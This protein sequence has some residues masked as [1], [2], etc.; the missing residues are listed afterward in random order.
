MVLFKKGKS[1]KL[2][3]IKSNIN[4]SKNDISSSSHN[5]EYKSNNSIDATNI[6]KLE[7]KKI[8]I[9]KFNKVDLSPSNKNQSQ[10]NSKRNQSYFNKKKLDFEGFALDKNFNDE[11]SCAFE[12]LINLTKINESNYA[13]NI[14]EN[15]TNNLCKIQLEKIKHKKRLEKS[16]ENM[17][18]FLNE[19]KSYCNDDRMF[20]NNTTIEK[21]KTVDQLIEKNFGKIKKNMFLTENRNRKI[22]RKDYNKY[23]DKIQLNE[24]KK[25]KDFLEYDGDLETASLRNENYT[26]SK[27]KNNSNKK[28]SVLNYKTNLNLENEVK[29]N[30]KNIA[31]KSERTKNESYIDN[32]IIEPKYLKLSKVNN[33]YYNTFCYGFFISGIPTPM[34]ENLIIEESINYLSP[35]CHKNCSSLFSIK[36]AIL[37]YFKNDL[38]EIE[39]S[40]LRKISNISFPLGIK[41]CIESSFDAKKTIQSPQQIFYNI[42]EN[43]NGERIY[44]CTKYF[45]IKENSDEFKKKY[46][47]DISL[48]LSE[49]IKNNKIFKKNELVLSQLLNS[50]TY[51]V[52]QSI[53]LLSKEPF[54]NPMATC[55]NGFIASI[56]EERANLINHIINEVPIPQKNNQIKFYL[57]PYFSP[58]ILNHEMNIY[59]VMAI[60]NQTK[61]K[62]SYYNLFLSREQLNYKKLYEYI[63]IEHIIFIFQMIILEQK[64]ILVDNNYK[65]LSELIFIF[66]N[67]IYPFSWRNNHIFP[68]ITFENI[69]FLQNK[70]PFICGMD[71]FVFSY[72][73]K[74]INNNTFNLENDI[75]IYNISQKCFIFSKNRKKITR[76]DLMHEY[77]L[78]SLPERVVN[79]ITKNIKFII[80]YINKND[81]M[82]NLKNNNNN[83][84]YEF[85]K[86]LILFKQNIEYDTKLAFIKGL[87]MLIGDYN[88]YTFFI[89]GEKPLFNKEAFIE[90]HKE[91]EF[92]YFLNQLIKTK[93][94]EEFLENEKNIYF[95]KKN[96]K[97]EN[98]KNEIKNDISIN[99]KKYYDTSYFIKIAYDFPDLINNYQI[100]KNSDSISNIMNKDTYFKAKTIC[101]KFKIIYESNKNNPNNLKEK[102][103]NNDNDSKNIQFENSQINRKK[104]NVLFS[105]KN[106]LEDIP[107]EKNIDTENKEF[108]NHKKSKNSEV[109]S[110]DYKSINKSGLKESKISTEV[111]TL[112]SQFNFINKN[113]IK[114]EKEENDEQKIIYININSNKNLFSNDKKNEKKYIIKKYLLTPFFLNLCRDDDVYIKEKITEDIII[115]EMK[116]YRKRKNIKDKIPPFSFLITIISKYINFD[117]Y[118]IKKSKIY[119]INDN[120]II[121][122]DK[123]EYDN[124]INNYLKESAKEV[125]S[126]KKKYFKEEISEK[127]IID[128]NNIY[129]K[130]EENILIN[131]FF[132][133]CIIN[134]PKIDNQNLILLKKLFSNIE[135][136]EYFANLIIPD[137]SLKN[138]CNHK[139]LTIYSFNIFSK[140]IKLSFENL[141]KNDNNLGRLLTL[142]CFIYYKIEKEKQIYIY[143]DFIINNS[144]NKQ[145]NSQPYELWNTDSFWIEFFNSE[146]EYNMREKEDEENEEEM[147][148]NDEIEDD[149]NNNNNK[150]ENDNIDHRRKMCLFKTVV[151]I[152]GIMFKLNLDKNF[153]LNIIEKMI[154]PVFI[155]DFL[156]INRIMK[157]ALIANNAN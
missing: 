30:L 108:S 97:N 133:S 20:Q 104:T 111:T 128:I 55:L 123:N 64:I 57:S 48:F 4:S 137:M 117:S 152:S 45:F 46:K 71:D 27:N 72:I 132:K 74:G 28:I 67:L 70:K 43:N 59:K 11:Q 107:E 73:D 79:Y 77:K 112:N 7:N 26:V 53:T 135:I 51:F 6:K 34:K 92:K 144:N 87:L 106:Y 21:T 31:N 25:E 29:N 22:D 10:I 17:K 69:N 157:L 118:N 83:Y 154:L 1:G 153:I 82:S 3:S 136:R 54:L 14:S 105:G 139:Q 121:K 88:N 113:E 120:Y 93:L 13:N 12:N 5:Q 44:T 36:P 90:S 142:A 8:S 94:F 148:E 100:K 23:Y 103:K 75:I 35:C 96:K 63:S 146:F 125:I 149:K 40:L 58:I 99:N 85:Y 47:F 155:N 98:E 24:I 89:E 91:K 68:I 115:K 119:Y 76:K 143:K 131:K 141:N 150:N 78:Y 41:L 15:Y 147:Y 156:Y 18:F 130:G 114:E 2:I 33:D 19:R 138:R 122:N 124:K 38:F 126:F 9:A 16:P 49:K 39:D 42:I 145:I 151:G 86:K 110:F 56:L 37:K 134:I 81:F 109:N 101:G 65:L 61:K 66:I 60:F 116:L 84:D 80:K 102:E 32:E 50:N 95:I 127:D 62:K 140:M 52:P 129:E